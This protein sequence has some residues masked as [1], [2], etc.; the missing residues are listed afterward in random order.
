MGNH[1]QVPEMTMATDSGDGPGVQWA[2]S[3]MQGWRPTMED[4]HCVHVSSGQRGNTGCEFPEG[5]PGG[6]EKSF[7]GVFDGHGGNTCADYLSKTMLRCITDS[8]QTDAKSPY[9]C[10]IKDQITGALIEGHY[11]ADDQLL[12]AVKTTKLQPKDTSGST[13]ISALVTTDAIYI[14]NCGDSRAVLARRGDKTVTWASKDHK[15]SNKEET[16][17]ILKAGGYVRGGR[18]D[19]DLAV[20]RSLGDFDLKQNTNLPRCSQKVSA[21]PDVKQF[22]RD[23]A[24]DFIVLACDGIWDVIDSEPCVVWIRNALKTQGD[25]GKVCEALI[26]YCCVELSSRDNMTVMIVVFDT[27]AE[28][29]LTG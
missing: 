20:S 14:S 28:C 16:S 18:V 23:N 11:L 29:A 17:R 25:L 2:V 13:A 1:L 12:H 21:E 19:G 6:N 4:S 22:A 8:Y 27:P 26:A 24:D 7:F 9:G 10:N 3:S 15:P 5:L